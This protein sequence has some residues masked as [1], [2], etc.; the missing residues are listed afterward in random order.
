MVSIL[1][2]LV[3]GYELNNFFFDSLCNNVLQ[4]KKKAKFL[5]KKKQLLITFRDFS[6]IQ[7]NF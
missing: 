5:E 2:K 6:K 7:I 1:L 3:V 4:K